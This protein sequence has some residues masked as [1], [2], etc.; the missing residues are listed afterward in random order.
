MP[1][2]Y[3]RLSDVPVS[4]LEGLRSEHPQEYARLYKA[5]FGIDLPK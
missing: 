5:E 4:D 1:Q 2:Q 3:A